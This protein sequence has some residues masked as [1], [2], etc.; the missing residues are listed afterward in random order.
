MS[1][2]AKN[3]VLIPKETTCNFDNSK[4]HT[5]ADKKAGS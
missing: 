5:A 4:G 1:R 2:I 3:R